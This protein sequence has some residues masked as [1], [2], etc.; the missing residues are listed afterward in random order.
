MNQLVDTRITIS[1][2]RYNHSTP[3]DGNIPRWVRTTTCLMMTFPHD[4][5][6][7]IHGLAVSLHRLPS[8]G[9]DDASVGGGRHLDAGDVAVGGFCCRDPGRLIDG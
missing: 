7:G 4:S 1:F 9:V 6:P 5:P 2:V 8:D 3:P